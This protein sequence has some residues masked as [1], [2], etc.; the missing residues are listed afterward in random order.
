MPYFQHPNKLLS[1]FLFSFSL[2]FSQT[3]YANWLEQG[4]EL[5]KGYQS[6]Q[7]KTTSNNANSL[8]NLKPEEIQQAF[9]QALSNGTETV[10]NQLGIKHG[11]NKDPNIHIP[12]PDSLKKV[13]STLSRFGMDKYMDS[14]ETKLNHA[15]ETA[16][17]KAKALFLQAIKEMS[18]E[19]VQKIYN[20]PADSATQYLK[21]KTTPQ[22]RAQM[23]PIINQSM[24]EVGAVKAYD[25][26][27]SEYKKMPFVPDIKSDLSNHVLDKSL[28]G[29]F[30]YIGQ[31]EAAI[32]KEPIK[33]TT[34]LLQ[35]VFGN[36]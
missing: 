19:D 33:Q 24:S 11:F 9:K 22:I 17:P 5:L 10:V 7:S 2:L 31:E 35:K 27:I 14:L 28:E 34:K 32:R 13:Q 3:V 16:T 20:G 18:F 1:T 15:A 4:A 23:A 26:A 29:I 30:Y 12:L 25:K 36:S 8:S 6:S 21:E